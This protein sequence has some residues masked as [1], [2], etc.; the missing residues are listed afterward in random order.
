MTDED[1]QSSDWE[2]PDIARPDPRRRPRMT[3]HSTAELRTVSG[4]LKY[5]E[6]FYFLGRLSVLV[7]PDVWN[8]ALDATIAEREVDA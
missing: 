4:T 2:S 6:V 3:T 5:D 8:A 1:S 7:D